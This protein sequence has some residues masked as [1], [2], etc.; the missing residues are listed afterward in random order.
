MLGRV[1]LV[2]LAMIALRPIRDGRI[3][4]NIFKSWKRSKTFTV[5]NESH[6]TQTNI[7]NNRVVIFSLGKCMRLTKSIPT[8]HQ[9]ST[10]RKNINLQFFEYTAVYSSGYRIRLIITNENG[11]TLLNKKK[12]SYTTH[13]EFIHT[14]DIS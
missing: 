6:E 8:S 7:F 1:L 11:P 2:V 13:E 10:F 5:F 9:H 12:I 14:A 3:R 4:V